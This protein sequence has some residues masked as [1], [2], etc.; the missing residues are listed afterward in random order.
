MYTE[1]S[2]LFKTMTSDGFFCSHLNSVKRTGSFEN[3]LSNNQ[4]F[5]KVVNCKFF[6]IF[7]PFTCSLVRPTQCN[8][9]FFQSG[10]TISSITDSAEKGGM[11]LTIKKKN[12]TSQI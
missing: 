2:M 3:L 4:S 7:F 5:L 9:L 6:I 10:P 11:M 8:H 12:A 1:F